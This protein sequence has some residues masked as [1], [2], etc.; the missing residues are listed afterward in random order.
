MTFPMSYDKEVVMQ[1]FEHRTPAA[2]SLSP[3]LQCRRP[4]S[5][6]I[7]YQLQGQAPSV[8][9]CQ[10]CHHGYSSFS[11]DSF[12]FLKEMRNCWN[13]AKVRQP[14]AAADHRHTWVFCR[15]AREKFLSDDL[16]AQTKGQFLGGS[17][18]AAW[19]TP[20]PRWGLGPFY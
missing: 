2:C 18:S 12:C 17:P 6:D 11:A 15:T 10:E 20:S 19:D 5:K 4:C 16:T 1:G 9:I 13:S 7:N 14:E 3:V 8:P